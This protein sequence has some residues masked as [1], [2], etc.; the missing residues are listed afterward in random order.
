V[1]KKYAKLVYNPVSGEGSFARNL[2]NVIREFQ[3][4][5][6]QLSLLR[7]LPDVPVE[8]MFTGADEDK[9]DAI[10]AAGGDGTLHQ[11]VNAMLKHNINLPLG[12]LPVGT[13]NDLATFLGIPDGIGECCRVILQENLTDID[14]GHINDR[15]FLNVA[16]G[17][18]LTDVPHNTPAR[19]KNMLGRLAYYAK[20]LESLPKFRPIPLRVMAQHGRWDDKFLLFL[21]LN[22]TSA[23]GFKRLAPKASIQDGLLDVLLIKECPFAELLPLFLRILRGQHL[24]SPHVVFFQTKELTIES[25]QTVHTDLDGELG[26]SLPLSVKSMPKALQIFVPKGR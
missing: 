5:G 24:N 14:A 10:F 21:V 19:L 2:D 8:A 18:L 26:P 13:V 6:W 11:T 20:G 7:T 22:S 1:G 4:G 17:G 12:I 16:S 25:S 9:F 23:G 15:Y 3:T